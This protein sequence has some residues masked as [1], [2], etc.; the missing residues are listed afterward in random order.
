MPPK[1]KNNGHGGIRNDPA[2]KKS[3]DQAEIKRTDFIEG[4]RGGL[5]IKESLAM[6]GRSHAW[7]DQTRQR[8]RAWAEECTRVRLNRDDDALA[9]ID[10]VRFRRAMFG[11]DTA[12]HHHRLIESVENSKPGELSVILGWPGLGKT[13]SLVDW[14]CYVLGREPDNRICVISEGQQLS[15]NIIGQVSDRMTDDQ[16]FP[17]Y[18]AKYG[19]FKANTW[20]DN[21]RDDRD[22]RKR[23]WTADYFTVLGAGADQKDPSL[24]SFGASSRIYGA[25]FDWMLFDDIQSNETLGNTDK[26]LRSLRTSW[27]SRINLGGGKLGKM[28][29]IGSR[30]GPGDIYEKLDDEGMIDNLVTIPA[31]TKSVPREEHF[32]VT[33]GNKIVV[34]ENCEAR[35]TWDKMSLMDLAILRKRAGEEVWARTYMQDVLTEHST[36]FTDEMIENA[37]DYDRIAGPAVV[38]QDV[39]ASIDPA[40]DSGLCAYMAAALDPSRLYILDTIALDNIRTYTDIYA[41][42]LQWKAVFRP[43]VWVVEENNFQKGMLQDDRLHRAAY[44]ADVLAHRTG[45]NKNDSVMGVRMMANA[46]NDREIRIPWGNTETRERMQ[47]LIDELKRWKPGAR[48]AILQQDRVMTLWFIWLRWQ[49]ERSGMD[50]VIPM[51]PRPSWVRGTA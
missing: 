5:T 1:K 12:P 25:R 16:R 29:M 31:M 19:P 32:I 51:L 24:A 3:R 20:D 18:H 8:H 47:P 15:R 7:Y 40:L 43:S 27:S 14:Y 10:F 46:F 30:V 38:G 35:P 45:R 26:Y 2:S 17:L 6:I 42:M 48:G 34:N 11:F 49:V 36:V 4:L 50:N 13:Q 41:K 33:P 37:K 21:D 28:V 9:S 44:P 22:P 23:G 39:W